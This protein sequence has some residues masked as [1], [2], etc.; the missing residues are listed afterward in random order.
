[1]KHIVGLLLAGTFV[2]GCAAGGEGTNSAAG[3]SGGGGASQGGGGSPASNGGAGGAGGVGGDPTVGSCGD[4]PSEFELECLTCGE[5]NCCQDFAECEV[6]SACYEHQVC[7]EECEDDECSALCDEAYPSGADASNALENCLIK[8]CSSQCY[9]PAAEETEICDSGITLS[10]PTCDA[11]LSAPCC[12]VFKACD[13]DTECA[14]CLYGLPDGTGGGAAA[15]G[16]DATGG[17][18]GG[19]MPCNGNAIYA[20]LDTCVVDNCA[21]ECGE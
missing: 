12:D 14:A 20:D 4:Y 19:A 16:A 8:Y 9:E 18:G 1:M 5:S 7:L 11:C 10:D 2:I 21:A 13:A 17:A 15:G 3:A 6:D